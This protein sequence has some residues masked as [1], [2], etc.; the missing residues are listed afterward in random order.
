MLVVG[1]PACLGQTPTK[2]FLKLQA[3]AKHGV[4]SSQIELAGLYL[5][6]NGIP[7]DAKLA[8]FWFEKA[9]QSGNGD[10]ENYMGYLYQS[11]T[12]VPK[13]LTR[14]FHWYQLAAASGSA[15]G[16]LNLGLLYLMGSGIPQDLPLATQLLEESARKGNGTAAAYLG[17]IFYFGLG[18]SRDLAAAEKWLRV[19]ANRHDP[20]ANY[21]LGSLYSVATDHAHDFAKAA[22]LL[23]CSAQSGYTPAMHSL[24]LLLVQHPELK[25][26]PEEAVT[27]LGLA[28]N[29]GQ[30]KS[31]VLLGILARDGRG[32]PADS[33]SALYHF[34][35][36][37]L[38]GGQEAEHQVSSEIN[39]LNF[40]MNSDA[41]EATAS[42]AQAWY[43]NHHSAQAFTGSDAS[44]MKFFLL[45]Q[46]PTAS[47]PASHS[48]DEAEEKSPGE[49][50]AIAD[51]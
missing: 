36:A 35:I 15:S 6:G 44:G 51:P 8:A 50:L 42:E 12:G 2:K 5:T 29:S 34:E 21:D 40:V 3:Q 14:A 31:T 11:G 22:E 28:M 10:A 38:Q 39:R 41:R 24:G 25:Q 4:V 18:G 47:V 30:W 9:A 46:P 17:Q 16:R 19:G 32:T 27:W 49:E 26:N 1:L 23:R 48:L 43:A 37:A 7:Q 33:R 20:I 13:D 45:D